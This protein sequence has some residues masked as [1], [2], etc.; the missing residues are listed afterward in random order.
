MSKY[1]EKVQV[2]YKDFMSSLTYKLSGTS[3]LDA[4]YVGGAAVKRKYIHLFFF[5]YNSRF[6]LRA[7][8]KMRNEFLDRV[9]KPKSKKRSIMILLERGTIIVQ[10]FL[11]LFLSHWE[12]LC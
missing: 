12:M 3:E 11:M 4:T 6:C 9:S 5:K 1:K 2:F 7:K 10:F 8:N